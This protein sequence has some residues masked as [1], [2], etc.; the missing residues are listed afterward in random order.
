MAGKKSTKIM[1]TQ[2]TYDSTGKLLPEGVEFNVPEDVSA[3]DAAI[4]VKAK[5]AKEVKV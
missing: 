3:E 5:K 2:S 4:I 1:V